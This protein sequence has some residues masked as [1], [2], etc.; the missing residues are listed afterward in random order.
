MKK[1]LL[2]LL[3]FTSLC[4][5]SQI[6]YESV[7]RTNIYDFL[8]EL[9][10]EKI[11]SINSVVKPY[12]RAFI[13]EKLQEANEHKDLLSKRQV[14]EIEFYMKDYRLEVVY[15]T[16]GMK[17]L[18]IF[19][20]KDHIAS[21]LDPMA[22]TY[23]DSLIGFTLR[24]IFGLEYFINSNEAAFHRW[25]GV[26]GFG[27]IG[28]NFGAYTSLRDNHENVIMT[29]T[30]YFNQRIGATIK[31]SAKGGGDYSD[32]RGGLMVSWNWGAFGIVKDQ[33]IWGNNYNGSNI[34]SGRTP[35]FAQIKLELKP[36][37]WFEFNYIHGWLVSDVIDSNRSYWDGD[38]YRD[39]MHSKYI[40]ANMFT[41]IPWQHLNLS[42]GNSIIYSDIGVQ[43]AY[44][45]PFL[46]Y[47]SVDHTLNSTNNYAGQNAQMFF[48][49]SSRNI[50][51]LHLYFT[52]FVDEFSISR[53]TN[54]SEHNFLSYKG[55]FRLSNWP[56][57]DL[58]LTTEFTYTL[59][60]TY[61]HRTSTTT[62]ES[63]SYN[64]GHYMRDNSMD[65]FFALTYKPIRGLRVDLSY[66]FAKH[67]NNYVYGVYE[68]GDQAPILKD[69]TWQESIIGLKGKYEF[70]NNAYVFA[71]I[72][73]SDIQGY[74][75]D[76]LTA[77]DYLTLF[78][79]EMYWGNTTTINV[80]FNIGF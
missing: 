28:K 51:H 41:F 5:T 29:S 11:I 80:G 72:F 70:I 34:L 58:S 42:F 56:L 77:E 27:Y 1:I 3:V 79:P 49:I 39:V 8:D 62:F 37:K 40:A 17:P 30:T 10:N 35:S 76:G 45:I 78:T 16:K 43:A 38:T 68:P 15:N 47:K 46:F 69:I 50:K 19:P 59:P 22:I 55:G 24:P 57:K 64:L 44:L 20:K 18:N 74:D 48:D 14:E 23:R 31:G 2:L 52:F 75:V 33:A 6:V 53:I 9:A 26:E 73:I 61:Q 63:N 32:A 66:A 65:I 36:A 60:M 7:Q 25:G 54:S 21:S 12:S 71:G 67:G 4:A 13:A